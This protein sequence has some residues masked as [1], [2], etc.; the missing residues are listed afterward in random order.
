MNNKRSYDMVIGSFVALGLVVLVVLIFLI[1]KE[2]RLFDRTIKI[3]A[4]FP[5]MPSPWVI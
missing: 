5:Y 4:H 2:R 3:K 1:G